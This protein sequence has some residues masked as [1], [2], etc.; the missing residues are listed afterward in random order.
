[1]LFL[2]GALHRH[3][4]IAVRDGGEKSKWTLQVSLRCCSLRDCCAIVH[5]VRAARD[6]LH[7]SIGLQNASPTADRRM[8]S[9]R[10][11]AG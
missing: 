1:M 6:L 10:K 8:T 9:L 4:D 5:G 11:W 2:A 3:A 7:R